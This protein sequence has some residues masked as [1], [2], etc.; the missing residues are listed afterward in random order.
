[1]ISEESREHER[2]AGIAIAA[3]VRGNPGIFAPRHEIEDCLASERQIDIEVELDLPVSGQ[4]YSEQLR[5]Q[6]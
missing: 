5:S 3:Y 4:Q 6:S 2:H 1:M